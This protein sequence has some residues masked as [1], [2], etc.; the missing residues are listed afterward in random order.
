MTCQN[1]NNFTTSSPPSGSGTSTP[2]TRVIYSEEYFAKTVNGTTQSSNRN[3]T[4]TRTAQGRWTVVL[5]TPHPE[6][7]N[8]HPSITVEEQLANRDSV[9]VHVIQGTQTATGFD[10]M[11]STG[12]NGGAA[13]TL[14]DTPF[15]ISIDSP[16]TVLE[17]I[18]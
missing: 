3:L 6:G 2:V 5:S 13:D 15:T 10:I 4:I 8:Y 14:V 9:D 1:N 11:L 16:V 7:I 12:D 18:I 17:N